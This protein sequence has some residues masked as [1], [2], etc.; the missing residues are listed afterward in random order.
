MVNAYS[1]EERSGLIK[2]EYMFTTLL[3][4]SIGSLVRPPTSALV[5]NSCM[6]LSKFL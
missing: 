1:F 4:K 2:I 5:P 6:T 3:D